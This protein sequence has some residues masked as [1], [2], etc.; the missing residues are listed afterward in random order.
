M[1]TAGSSIDTGYAT[2]VR[3]S[4]QF[5]AG[6]ALAR[7]IEIEIETALGNLEGLLI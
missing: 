4:G 6:A 7:E 2:Y 5:D 3:T 1:G